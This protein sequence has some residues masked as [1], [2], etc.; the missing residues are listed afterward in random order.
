VLLRAVDDGN[1]VLWMSTRELDQRICNEKSVRQRHGADDRP[2][3]LGAVQCGDSGASLLELGER[4]AGAAREALGAARWYDAIARFLEQGD[5]KLSLE[6]ARRAENRRLSHVAG[7]RCQR[8]VPMLSHRREGAKLR[9]AHSMREPCQRTRLAAGRG[10]QL[11]DAFMR[12]PR[13]A[14]EP[15]CTH[16]SCRGQ[17]YTRGAA[18]EQ[19]RTEVPLDLRD[20]PGNGRL[21][22]VH[23]ASRGADAAQ[24][25]YFTDGVKVPDI[26]RHC[27]LQPAALTTWRR[28][29]IAMS[30]SG[31]GISIGNQ[32]SDV[33]NVLKQD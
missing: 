3:V 18:Y 13:R 2:A 6:V 11:D 14:A 26:E 5:F 12:R 21:R 24:L 22:Q 32:S 17:L 28:T 9:R 16:G 10:A 29:T 27:C 1:A 19:A 7:T 25:G 33:D 31:T 20:R 8:R 23:G 15:L 4:H 30:Y